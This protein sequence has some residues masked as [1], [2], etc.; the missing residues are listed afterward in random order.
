MSALFLSLKYPSFRL[1]YVFSSFINEKMSA[2]AQL[3]TIEASSKQSRALISVLSNQLGQLEKALV[4]KKKVELRT[5]NEEL[6]KRLAQIT[7]DLLVLEQI[8]G[9]EQYYDFTKSDR[10]APVVTVAGEAPKLQVK[11]EPKPAA[12]AEPKPKPEPVANGSA[13]EASPPAQQP[14]KKEKAAKKGG[15]GAKKAPAEEAPVDVSRLDFRVGRI[16]EAQRHPDAESLYVEQIDLGEAAPRTV[17]SGLVKFVPLEE[18]SGR[19]VVCL[20]NLKPAKMR[21]VVSQAMVMCAS[22]PDKVEILSPPEGAQPGDLVEFPPFPRTPDALL[23][24]KKKVFETCAPD[25]RTSQ[26][27]V[28]L[29]RDAAM[30][31]PGKGAVTAQTLAGVAVK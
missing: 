4:E 30:T 13:K 2:V 23:N 28:A 11:P 17:V 31:V 27:R 8:K 10:L 22:T 1:K 20:C 21:G 9:K 24:P 19:L 12:K 6:K 25:L 3:R 26:D 16:V 5:E 14:P 15:G 18:M 29:F 7:A